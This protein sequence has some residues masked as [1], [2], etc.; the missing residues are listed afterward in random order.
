MTMPSINQINRIITKTPGTIAIVLFTLLVGLFTKSLWHSADKYGLLDSYGYGL[1]SFSEGRWWTIA[2]GAAISPKPWMYVIIL[3]V[4]I[5]GCGFIEYHYGTMRMLGVVIITHVGSILLTALIL[6]IFRNYNVVWA[7]ELA[8]V[9]DLGLSNA[10]FGAVGAASTGLAMLWRR[11]VRLFVLLYCVTLILY[12]G[13]IWDLTH[14]IAFIIGIAIGPWVVGKKYSRSEFPLLNLEPRSLIVAVA[15]LNVYGLVVSRL[16]PGDGGIIN[17][18]QSPQYTSSF[19]A[20]LV[21]VLLNII[22]IYGLYKGKRLA[23]WVVLILNSITIISILFM[24]NSGLKLYHLITSGLLVCLLVA[25]RQLFKVKSDKIVRKKLIINL[26][27][28]FG[29]I[30]VMHVSLIYSFRSSINP[31]PTFAQTAVDSIFLVGQTNSVFVSNERPVRV[32]M[33][34]IDYIWVMFILGF[35]AAIILST[36]RARNERAEYD[37]FDKLMRHNGSTT[38]TWM[39]RW[40]GM[41]Y[42]ANKSQTAAIAYRLINNVAIVLSDP[43]GKKQAATKATKS[44]HEFCTKNGWSVAYFSVTEK[45]ANT[46]SGYGF[47]KIL[48]GEDTKIMLDNLEFAGKK[49]QSIRSAIN[50]ADKA[51][52]TMQSIKLNQAPDNIKNQLRDIA[53]SW[54]ADKSLPE[55]GFTLGTLKEAED[56]AVIMNIAVDDNDEVHGMTSW[57][58]VYKS[59]KIIGWTIDIMQRRLSED[60]I[61]GVIEFLIAKSAMHFK[62][63]GAKFISLS[64]APLSN[65]KNNKTSI[66]KLLTVLADRLEPYYGFKSLHRFKEKFQ[67]LHEPFYLCYNDE[68]QLPGIAAAI[69]KAYMNDTSYIKAFASIVKKH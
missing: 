11:R 19:I 36:K 8:K 34:S 43:V 38:I 17:F 68:S 62:D 40:P 31:V 49:W 37:T 52:V 5:L 1:P 64:A 66:E 27:I 29:L 45:F 67:P 57:M 41:S 25:Y 55:M 56:P 6:V 18:G 59:G 20:M 50:K 2:T 65:S 58:P 47:S 35:L 22:F 30:Y 33:A 15:S 9:R 51:G 48:V 46:L 32:L 44:F 61:G 13:L 24:Q 14:F 69:G 12:S 23:W 28:V 39:A 60:T 63:K 7:V 26:L 42:W 16:F 4:V 10:G 53:D 3:L 21:S 54:V